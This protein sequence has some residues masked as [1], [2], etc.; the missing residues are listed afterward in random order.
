[1]HYASL[2]F[3]RLLQRNSACDVELVDLY[4]HRIRRARVRHL[5][6]VLVLAHLLLVLAHLLLVLAHLL[7]VL[8]HLL[9]VLAHLLLLATS[10]IR[11]LMCAF[12]GRVL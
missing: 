4:D 2:H 3:L 8:A 12:V 9:L 11:P 6:L 1:M 7:L 5:V 10:G